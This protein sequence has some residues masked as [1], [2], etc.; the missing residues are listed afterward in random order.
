MVVTYIRAY[1]ATGR[2]LYLAKAESLAN[3]LTLAQQQYHG[4]YP[5]RMYKTQDRTYWINSSV[6]TVRAMDM[7]ARTS[8]TVHHEDHKN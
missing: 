3:A 1:Q 2:A 7:L 4:R 5:T 8:S 6:N